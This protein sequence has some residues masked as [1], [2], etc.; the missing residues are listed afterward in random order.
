MIEQAERLRSDGQTVMFLA[1]DGR[2]LGILGVVDPIK[3][4]SAQAIR[5]L[6]DDGI[7]VMMLTGDNRATAEA[8]G[9]KLGIDRIEADLFPEDK[10]ESFPN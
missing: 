2:L 3:E 5:L 7:Q 8:V 6:H 10:I 1:V 4:S 9:R